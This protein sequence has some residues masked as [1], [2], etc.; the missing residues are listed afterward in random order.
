MKISF[1]TLG[2]KVN[3]AETQ[4]IQEKFEKMGYEVTEFGSPSD[5]ILI[6]T[7]TVT[8][9]A[10]SEAGKLIRRARRNS[11]NAFLGVF[12]CFAQLK[13]EE[14]LSNLPVDAVF[15]QKEKFH[16][17]TLVNEMLNG[18]AN[19]N[20]VSCIDELKFDAALTSDNSERTRAFL[21]MQDG[22]NYKCTF[23]TIPL[24]RGRSRSMPMEEIPDY[25]Y[26]I[27]ENGYKEVVISGINL[28]D[29]KT[30]DGKK[31]ID[32][33]KVIDNLN[34]D[35]RVRIS[36]IEPNLLTDEILEVTANSNMF[37]PHFHIPLQSGSNEILRKMKRRYTAD[38]YADLVHK[39]KDRIPN[40][41][42][43]VDVISGFPGETIEHFNETKSF[44]QSLPITYLHTF[45]YSE[46]A[47]TPAIHF[48]GKVPVNI[49]KQRTKELRLLSD[50]KRI[51]FMKSQIG[52]TFTVIP[53]SKEENSNIWHGWTENYI[54]VHFPSNED[55]FSKFIK[56]RIESANNDFALASE[57]K[58]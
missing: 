28:G 34:L 20:N 23:C 36:S 2:C 5:V 10:D 16:I 57:F 17:P 26:K 11:P 56:V 51:E 12:G 21:K 25:F 33:V 35:L 46:R 19:Q 55:I 4:Q 54:R 38:F 50:S 1:H 47:D 13:P 53:E 7:C 40:C 22:C 45:T 15:G 29:Y 48:D 37:C 14:I 52:N 41:G 9:N 44:L 49:R 30:D 18:V 43:G 31:F 27:V 39:I 32:A 24:A 6:N 58:S 42:I 3:Y 8:N